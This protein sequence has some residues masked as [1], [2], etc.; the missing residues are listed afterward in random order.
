MSESNNTNVI[1]RKNNQ[2]RIC[3]ATETN[4]THIE[5]ERTSREISRSHSESNGTDA[6]RCTGITAVAAQRNLGN[7]EIHNHVEPLCNDT[8][9]PSSNYSRTEGSNKPLQEILETV[10]KRGLEDVS[11]S[12]CQLDTI[13][14]TEDL[15][16]EALSLTPTSAE[17]TTYN[18]CNNNER[19]STKSPFCSVCLA[20][21]TTQ[22]IGTTDTCNHNFCATCLQDWSKYVRTCPLDRQAF[23][24]I[25]VRQ[26]LDGEVIRTIPVDS[27]RQEL[28][29][30]EVCGECDYE[31]RM[32][33]CSE[34]NS[35]CHQTC[36]DVDFDISN[37]GVVL[38]QICLIGHLVLL[39]EDLVNE[40]LQPF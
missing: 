2:S 40:L 12:P 1:R 38:C 14:T 37:T 25:L 13:P 34:C 19:S 16:C 35:A 8:G 21:F 7:G 39:V 6:G 17:V 15:N 10:E 28:L 26:H 36:I 11:T 3:E 27:L 22:E 29:F 5:L 4:E 24:S 32:L 9:R 18:S 20:K 31:D 30:C 23:N 33:V